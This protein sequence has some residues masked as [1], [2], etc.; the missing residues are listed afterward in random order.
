MDRSLLIHCLRKRIKSIWGRAALWERP[1]ERRGKALG[2]GWS[3]GGSRERRLAQKLNVRLGMKPL[4]YWP[5]GFWGAS[6]ASLTKEIYRSD[7]S[8]AFE[9]FS[10]IFEE[11]EI[12]WYFK[13]D[14]AGKCIG[15]FPNMNNA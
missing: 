5:E 13:E 1:R 15:G 2:I 8:V 12:I 7:V 4:P 10:R 6:R 14:K 3:R 11:N 9:L